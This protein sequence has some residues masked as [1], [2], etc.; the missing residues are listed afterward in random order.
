MNK[1]PLTRTEHTG[2]I[3]LDSFSGKA[4]DIP[5]KLR[6]DLTV[7]TA[8]K[9]DGRV[10]V[11]DMDE[12]GLYSWIDSLERKEFI[13]SIPEGYPWL[14]YEITDKGKE[15]LE[16]NAQSQIKSRAENLMERKR[17]LGMEIEEN[18]KILGT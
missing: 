7:L 4:A 3:I 13:T 1:K 18:N 8:L 5:K 10:S 16:Q 15:Y 14:R 17:E 12:E 6:S 9:S 2:R 11:W